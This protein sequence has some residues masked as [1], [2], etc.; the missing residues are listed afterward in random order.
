MRCPAAREEA[1]MTCTSFSTACRA[2]SSGV[3]KREPMSTSQPRSAKAVAMT[4]WPR[5]W[6]SWPILATSNAGAPAGGLRNPRAALARGVH[7]VVAVLHL[8]SVDAGDGPDRRAVPP[9]GVLHGGGD[10]ADRRPARAA[11]IDRAEEVLSSVRRSPG[12]D[13]VPRRRPRGRAPYRLGPGRGL[14]LQPREL[15]G[16]DL[17]V[18]DGE[19]GTSSSWSGRCSLTPMIGLRP[20]SM[21]GLARAAASSMRSLGRPASI[22]VVM[23]PRSSTSSMCSSARP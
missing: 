9:E 12:L 4:F 14:V 20:E 16:A 11:S 19:D 3:W 6:P 23:P 8:G 1:P 18:V 15:G 22:A 17:G 5:S 21:R 2:V 13:L 7:V 10:L